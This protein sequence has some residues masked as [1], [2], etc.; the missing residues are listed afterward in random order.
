MTAQIIR[1]INSQTL[2][3]SILL[4]K[5]DESQGNTPGYAAKAKQKLYVPYKNPVDP[6]VQ[7][8][9]DLIP[10]DNVQLAQRPGGVIAGLAASGRV[11][12]SPIT[13]AQVATPVIT[14]AAH[15]AGDTT[16]TGTTFLSV[17]PDHT[18]ATLFNLTGGKQTIS[19]TEIA[20]DQ[21]TDLVALA[22]ELKT[23]LNAHEA[24]TG[25]VWHTTPDGVNVVVAANATNLAT[26]ITLLNAVKTAYEAHRVLVGAGPVHGTADATNVIVAANATD[27]AS[28]ITLSNDLKAK[29]N[30]HRID[31][32]GAPQVHALAD[33]VNVTTGIN[34]DSFSNTQIKIS[35]TFVTIGTPGAGWKVQVQANSKKSNI[36]TL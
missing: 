21:L 3:R 1:V 15:A 5:I 11:T 32:A 35:D 19:D 17:F 13:S 8:Y 26:A 31:V 20:A 9:V 30:A 23:D 27:L 6:S 33:T 2:V 36:F 24:N 4:D 14:G 25:G 7:G 22:N 18:Y 12:T 16:I 28:A 34:G 29:Y 10:T